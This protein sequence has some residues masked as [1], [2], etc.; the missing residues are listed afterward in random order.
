M[1]VMMWLDTSY[2]YAYDDITIT[3]TSIRIMMII[4]M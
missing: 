2:I 4:I 3:I 1:L